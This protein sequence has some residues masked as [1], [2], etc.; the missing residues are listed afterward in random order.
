M[1]ASNW[2]ASSRIGAGPRASRI[3]QHDEQTGM[4]RLDQRP[5][6]LGSNLGIGIADE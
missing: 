4:A 3:L 1:Q 6:R 5:Q 2:K